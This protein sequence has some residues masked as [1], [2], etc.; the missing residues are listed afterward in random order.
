MYQVALQNQKEIDLGKAAIGGIASI[1]TG[2]IEELD[3]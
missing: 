2:Y 1:L 3:Y